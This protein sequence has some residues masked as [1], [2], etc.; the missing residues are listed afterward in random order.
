MDANK[1]PIVSFVSACSGAGKTTLLEK[2]VDI[3]KQRGL[4]L[5]VIKHDAHRFEMDHPGKDTWRLAQAGENRV[6]QVFCK[7]NTCYVEEEALQ[8]FGDANQLF[9]NL[10]TPQDWQEALRRKEEGHGS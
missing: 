6:R 1:I 7:V 3:L 8:L 4:R 9:F 10:N 5:A 2:V